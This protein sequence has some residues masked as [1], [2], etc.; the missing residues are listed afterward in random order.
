MYNKSIHNLNLNLSE[1]ICNEK[2]IPISINL[3]YPNQILN[4]KKYS[5]ENFE[6]N[7]LLFTN[8][9]DGTKFYKKIDKINW[10]WK[11]W[12]VS[13]ADVILPPIVLSDWLRGLDL[14]QRPSGYEPDAR[15]FTLSPN[16]L[17]HIQSL[18]FW[19]H[20]LS[21]NHGIL[22]N[23]MSSVLSI[24][25]ATLRKKISD[26]VLSISRPTSQPSTKRL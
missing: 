18:S 2:K 25:L 23:P 17:I 21:W 5:I 22:Q 16:D 10:N 7:F 3:K 11:L 8:M 19:V 14:D 1:I 9:I 6:C 24:V 15:Y 20:L 13:D 12:L 26:I 4:K